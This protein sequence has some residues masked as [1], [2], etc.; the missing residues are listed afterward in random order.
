MIY[1]PETERVSH[2][3]RARIAE[4]FDVVVHIDETHALAPLEA[5]S[6]WHAGEPPET[7]PHGV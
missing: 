5:T 1:R 7:E 6:E 2:Y 3:L 4:Q